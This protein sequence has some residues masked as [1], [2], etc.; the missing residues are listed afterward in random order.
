MGGKSISGMASTSPGYGVQDITARA[1]A[2]ALAT[3]PAPFESA[4][5]SE[6]AHPEQG[7][8][9]TLAERLTTFYGKYNKSHVGI[10]PEIAQRYA[11][12]EAELSTLL[13]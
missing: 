1:R 7:S 3:L 12:R 10:A 11:G 9:A 4:G 2:L 8:A 13:R 6:G 5:K